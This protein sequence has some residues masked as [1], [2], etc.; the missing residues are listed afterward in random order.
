[1]RIATAVLLA[2]LLAGCSSLLYRVPIIQGN[3]L[4]SESVSKLKRGM[5]KPE[6][7]YLLGTPM[8]NSDF[9]IHRWDYVF[10]L[11]NTRGQTMQS[12]L[13][14]FFKHGKVVRI[15]GD[16]SYTALLPEN[17]EEMG[18]E[19]VNAAESRSILPGEDDNQT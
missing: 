11:R 15:A 13:T 4:D 5:T 17:R 12:R 19:D 14:V 10:Y 16:E 3:V 2:S 9:G 6:V 1:M 18:Y 7:R 8:V